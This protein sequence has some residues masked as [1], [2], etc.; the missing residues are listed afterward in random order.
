LLLRVRQ[1]IVVARRSCF[2]RGHTEAVGMSIFAST[3][4]HAATDEKCGAY[5]SSRKYSG[6]GTASTA[7]EAKEKALDECN[8]AS[9]RVLIADCN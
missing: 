2:E 6:T 5:A 9:C 4:R 8:N 7:Q 1:R 3:S